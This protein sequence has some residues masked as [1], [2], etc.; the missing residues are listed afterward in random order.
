MR[1]VIVSMNITMDGFMA[2]RD[3][4]LEW[5]F[6]YWNDEMAEESARQLSMADTIV[7]GRKTYEAMAAYWPL[8]VASTALPRQ[9]IAFAEMMNNHRKIV[10]S[11]RLKHLCWNNSLLISSEPG[12]EIGCLKKNDGADIL[13][14]GSGS[15]VFSL[16]R[17]RLIDEYRIWVHPVVLGAGRPF[18]IDLMNKEPLTLLKQKK[19]A[20]GVVLYFYRVPIPI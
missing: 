9:D 14:Y 11:T 4:G 18:F 3:T 6:R 8:Q 12:K 5:H 2:A 15:I 20:S 17:S 13:V 19:F 1:K 16:M 7:L 10:F